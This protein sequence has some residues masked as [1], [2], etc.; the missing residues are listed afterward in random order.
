MEKLDHRLVINEEERELITK[1][2]SF[3][4]QYEIGGNLGLVKL[5][6]AICDS[7]N[8][9][10]STMAEMS[11]E[12]VY[13]SAYL[14][15]SHISRV[16]TDKNRHKVIFQQIESAY[17]DAINHYLPSM[18]FPDYT[19]Y[20]AKEQMICEKYET[21]FK[22]RELMRKVHSVLVLYDD[23][24]EPFRKMADTLNNLARTK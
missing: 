3:I 23:V 20:E 24:I 5:D 12:D 17:K 11:S 1:I 7:L 4:N 8:I 15:Q 2:E 18:T 21:V 14:I 19:K 9:D 13:H 6:P 16:I 22:L 10:R